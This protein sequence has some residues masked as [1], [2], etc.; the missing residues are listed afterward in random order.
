M[1]DAAE[2]AP[3]WRVLDIS[4]GTGEAA[5]M[6][7]P[8]VGALGFV[9]GADMFELRLPA[10]DGG[11]AGSSTPSSHPVNA[12]SIASCGK[13][14]VMNTIRVRRSSLGHCGSS[15]PPLPRCSGWA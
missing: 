8:I 7:L 3:G 6:M 14:R 9:V 10:Q 2:V 1:L 5:L 15:L 13:S 12:A 4:T 11:S